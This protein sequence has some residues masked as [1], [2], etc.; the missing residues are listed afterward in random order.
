[1]KIIVSSRCHGNI[2]EVNV[3]GVSYFIDEY[4]KVDVDV[5]LWRD[6]SSIK[7]GNSG[8]FIAYDGDVFICY[9]TIYGD[10]ELTFINEKTG[11]E[12]IFNSLRAWMPLPEMPKNGR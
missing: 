5:D 10:C 4:R 1:M 6:M 9:S 12:V 8:R 2:S 3:N 7:Y 11:D